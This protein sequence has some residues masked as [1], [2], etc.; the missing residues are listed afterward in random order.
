M[1]K[2]TRPLELEYKEA[3]KLLKKQGND[4]TSIIEKYVKG[5]EDELKNWENINGSKGESK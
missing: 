2:V 1:K 4:Q 5:L 3:I